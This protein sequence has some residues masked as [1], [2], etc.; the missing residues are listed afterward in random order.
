[1]SAPIVLA[2]FRD[3]DTLVE[4]ARRARAAGLKGLDA[5]TPFAVEGLSDALAL[6]APRLRP[7]MLGAAALGAGFVYLMCWYSGVIDYPLNLG[8]RPLHAW[9]VFLVL[10]FEAGILA[11]TFT[12]IAGF[13]I[14]TGLPRLNHPV[15]AARDF[16]RASQD[17]FFLSVSDEAADAERLRALLDGLGPISIRAVQP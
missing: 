13:F 8:A 9:P 14:G 17:R 11:A 1:M 5:Y 15:F 12:G 10:A 6:E 2:E 4:A 7:A 3:P 16:D